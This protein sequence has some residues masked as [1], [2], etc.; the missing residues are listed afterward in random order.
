MN[1]RVVVLTTYFRPI[2]GGVE[3]NAERL[4]RYLHAHGFGVQ[5]LTKRFT[6]ELP[7]SELLDGVRVDRIGPFGERSAAGKWQMLPSAIPWLVRHAADYD[8]VCC[9]DY[10][11][12]G[13]AAIAARAITG[14]A[15]C[16]RPRRP[17]GWSPVCSSGRSS[18]SIAAPTPSP[19]S[20]TGWSARRGGRRAGKTAFTFCRTRST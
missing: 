11:G 17:A 8:V 14:G 19:A 1:P 13:I 2:V 16:F 9:V 7:D 20:R 4:A 18:R 10:R 3:S 15:S 6:P 12:V 5:V